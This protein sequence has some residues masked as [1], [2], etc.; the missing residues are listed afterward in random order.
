[1]LSSFQPKEKS[2]SN[3]LNLS[4]NRTHQSYQEQPSSTMKKNAIL[5][6]DPDQTKQT[7]GT[8]SIYSG[9]D[10]LFSCK[11]L[12]LPWLNNQRRISCIPEGTYNVIL[13]NSPKFGKCFWLQDVPGRSE[14]LIHTGNYAGS[15]N[16]K[17]G[18]S[19][20]LGCILVGTGYADLDGDGLKDI[21]SSKVA[22]DELLRLLT[23]EFVLTIQN[24]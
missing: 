3:G 7:Y 4:N 18:K 13:H 19:D 2:D 23:S 14:I 1:L 6:R 24:K 15:L 21:T 8:L 10:L 16:P 17:T 5:H 9:T 20:I 11:T 22:M 12:E